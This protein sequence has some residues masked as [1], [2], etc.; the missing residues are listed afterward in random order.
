[1]Y[2]LVFNHISFRTYRSS[3]ESEHNNLNR[4]LNERCDLACGVKTTFNKNQH[5]IGK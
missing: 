3:K 5:E 2:Y 1:M 4:N